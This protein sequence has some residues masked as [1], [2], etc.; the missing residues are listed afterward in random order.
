MTKR[1]D[2]EERVYLA[3]ASISVFIIKGSQDRKLKTGQ[4]PGGRSNRDHEGVLLTGLLLLAC[5]ACFLIEARTTSP[6][7][8]PPTTAAPSPFSY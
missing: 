8:A 4:E 2:V 6:G 7:E 1:Q 5:S 3:Y